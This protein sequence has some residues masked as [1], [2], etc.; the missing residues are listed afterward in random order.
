MGKSKRKDL[1]WSHCGCCGPS[2]R[3]VNKVIRLIHRTGDFSYLSALGTWNQQPVPG[4][5][6]SPTRG[7]LNFPSY[8]GA[9]NLHGGLNENSDKARGH[10]INAKN[11]KRSPQLPKRKEKRKAPKSREL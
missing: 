5:V 3:L 2:G 6:Q 11:P 10:K 9:G 7:V 4:E 8:G 1:E